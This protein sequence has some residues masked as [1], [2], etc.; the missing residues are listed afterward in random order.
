MEIKEIPGD[1]G[2][3]SVLYAARF[4]ALPGDDSRR[5]GLDG[6][7]DTSFETGSLIF[8]ENIIIKIL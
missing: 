1:D 7:D 8:I 2:I 3:I 4:E 6:D 5:S